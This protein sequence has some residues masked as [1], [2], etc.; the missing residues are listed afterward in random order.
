[1]LLRALLGA[2]VVFVNAITGIDDSP[3]FTG[4]SNGTFNRIGRKESSE[5][6]VV[7]VWVSTSIRIQ[8]ELTHSDEF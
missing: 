1:V 8:T 7:G 4:L 2:I 6:Y 5:V 3:S